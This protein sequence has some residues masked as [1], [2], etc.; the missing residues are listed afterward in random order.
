M[1]NYLFLTRCGKEGQ[2]HLVRC[3]AISDALSKYNI[4]SHFVINAKDDG[5]ILRNKK[6]LAT[7]EWQENHSRLLNFIKEYKNIFIDS[8]SLN[9]TLFNKIN[10]HANNLIYIDDFKRWNH[11]KGIII[12]WTIGVKKQKNQKNLNYLFSSK[13]TALRKNFWK[14][15]K[16]I[17]NKEI[18]NI[19]ISFSNDINKITL[20][21]IPCIK[22]VYPNSNISIV[23]R[24]RIIYKKFINSKK[25]KTYYNINE[26]II[27]NLMLKNDLAIAAGGV[28][29]YELASLGIPTLAVIANIN[30]V[31]DVSGF[32]KA[33]IVL[34]CG[35]WN[36]KSFNKNVIKNL[37]KTKSFE[38]RQKMSSKG[39]KVIDGLGALRIAKHIYKNT[40]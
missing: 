12:D 22:I 35:K 25:I 8:L 29:L 2:G 30:Q 19:L 6:I 34:N 10:K 27:K 21:V 36:S 16:N 5:A 15:K 37:L 33:N 11:K 18:N 26:N 28:T 20:K 3:E 17:L 4:K 39:Q 23:T 1:T 24:S 31:D 32:E 9:K 14:Q 40:I 38:E 7:F 13:Y